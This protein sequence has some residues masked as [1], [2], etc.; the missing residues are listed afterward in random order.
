MLVAGFEIKG[1]SKIWVFPNAFQCSCNF[2]A[3]VN[4]NFPVPKSGSGHAIKSND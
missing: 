4:P 2:I 1:E 3:I